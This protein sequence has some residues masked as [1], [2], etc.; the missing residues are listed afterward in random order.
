MTSMQAI[1]Y[2]MSLR[3]RS[4]LFVLVSLFALASCGTI[5]LEVESPQE[6]QYG[7]RYQAGGGRWGERVVLEAA[8]LPAAWFRLDSDDPLVPSSDIGSADGTGYGARAAI[9]NRDQSIGVSYQGFE[10]SNDLVDIDVES[11]Y[12][13][14]DVR[15]PLADGGGNFDL[16]VGAGLGSAFLDVSGGNTQSIREGAAQLRFLLSFRPTQALSFD[17]G[18]GG[19]VYGHPGDTEAFG[20]FLQ[21]GATLTF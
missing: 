5:P 9:G 18:G 19:V 4:S 12:L 8:W 11:V 21:V 7:A 17:F 16:V 20:S 3:P 13:D 6:P 14:F 10:L 15:V 1:P 2:A